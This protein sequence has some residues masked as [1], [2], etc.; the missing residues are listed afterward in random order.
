M[1]DSTEYTRLY[2]LAGD[3]E[4]AVFFEFELMKHPIKHICLLLNIRIGQDDTQKQHTMLLTRIHRFDK[5]ELHDIVFDQAFRCLVQHVYARLFEK[6]LESNF[7]VMDL[8]TFYTNYLDESTTRRI[9][10]PDVDVLAG[11]MMYHFYKHWEE[12]TSEVSLRDYI[13]NYYKEH[14]VVNY[15][16]AA[17]DSDNKAIIHQ[18]SASP[19][20]AHNVATQIC[21]ENNWKLTM[22]LRKD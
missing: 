7:E 13:N 8:S 3:F 10:V 9:N 12:D 14:T 2:K 21:E 18:F 19:I 17:Y 15:Q 16:L 20:Y 5:N 1:F 11:A 4:E 22:Y 6:N